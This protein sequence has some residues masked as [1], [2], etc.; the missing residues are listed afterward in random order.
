MVI[1]TFN[2][3][4]N[5]APLVE[6]L[7][8]AI[9]D[10]EAEVIFVDDSTDDTAAVIERI[11]FRSE[12]AI[13]LIHRDEAVGGLAGAVVTG[14]EAALG[15]WCVVMDG[16]L[17]HPP[18]LLPRLLAAGEEAAADV[19]VASRHVTGGSSSGLHDPLRHLVSSAATVLARSM[20]PLR[21]RD[22][23]D[24]MTGYFAIRRSA[25]DLSALRPRGFKILLEILA[26]RRYRVVEVPL[27]FAE[28]NA[29]HSKATAAQGLRF[30]SQLAALRFGRLSA[31]AT[32]GALGAL[33]NLLI[34]GGMQLAGVW[35]P[36]AAL[37]A[38]VVTILGNF[39]LLERFVFHDLRTARFGLLR[40]FT[41]SFAFNMGEA[42]VRTG[43]LWLIVETTVIPSLP[44]QAALI[45]FGFIVRFVFHARVIYRPTPE[46]TTAETTATAVQQRQR[47]A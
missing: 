29:G 46:T 41:R 27:L 32:V 7:L 10:R 16:D 24:P 39:V 20:F 30:V 43:V 34:M 40:R 45:G 3:A 2:E 8:A 6:R 36:I 14:L 38:A 25:V 22:C 1:P 28:R 33:A 23:T 44:A 26:R 42:A 21:L 35:Y 17:Q 11:A 47:P 18:E 37:V 31:F 13:R 15:E 19:A 9:G 5:I 12:A 4:P